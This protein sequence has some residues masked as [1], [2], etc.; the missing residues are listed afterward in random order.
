MRDQGSFAKKKS[1]NT[2]KERGELTK[3]WYLVDA[4]RVSL[5]CLAD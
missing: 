5:R 3:I 4:L 1:F 2:P